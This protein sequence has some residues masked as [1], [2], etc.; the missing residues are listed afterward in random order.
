MAH[1]HS[2]CERSNGIVTSGRRQLESAQARERA[3]GSRDQQ[4]RQVGRE[5]AKRLLLLDSLLRFFFLFRLK[6]QRVR[7]SPLTKIAHSS[8][9]YLG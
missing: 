5:A 3:Q 9:P 7:L 4:E 1:R 8:H 2:T 6:G